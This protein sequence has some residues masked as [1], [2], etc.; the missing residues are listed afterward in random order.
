MMKTR[1]IRTPWNGNVGFVIDSRRIRRRIREEIKH[2]GI[3][4]LHY[5]AMY[6][7]YT[8]LKRMIYRARGTKIGRGVHIS[9]GVFIEEIYPWLV[10]IEDGVSIAPRVTII[11]HDSCWNNIDPLIPTIKNRIIIKKN[12][13]IGAGA[14]ILKGVTI[15]EYSIV[16]A[17]AVVTKDVPPRTIVAGVPAK[18]IGNVDERSE[19]IKGEY[20]NLE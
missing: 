16:G 15:G 20:N 17:G 9:C 1:T 5:M 2:S 13:Y 3:T 14:I 10:T 18:I 12:A 11:T 19:R 4:F 6:C 7:P 8:P